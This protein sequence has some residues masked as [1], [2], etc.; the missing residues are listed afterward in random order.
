MVVFNFFI[1]LALH[2]RCFSPL[3]NSSFYKTSA[4][5]DMGPR[6]LIMAEGHNFNYFCLNFSMT[7]I[8]FKHFSVIKLL[9]CTFIRPL[10]CFHYL[11]K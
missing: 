3:H 2:C 8:G 11:L 4:Q 7:V 1:K 5:S 10:S 6:T 9:K